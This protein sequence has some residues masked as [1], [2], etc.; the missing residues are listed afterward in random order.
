MA[1]VRPKD[2]EAQA[3]HDRAEQLEYEHGSY[4][5]EHMLDELP[6][7]ELEQR[8]EE[9]R[10]AHAKSLAAGRARDR[11]LKPARWQNFRAGGRA[12]GTRVRPKVKARRV[13]VD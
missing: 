13:G 3:L 9:I 11:G 5:R 1:R 2:A 8:R 12:P 7:P 10:K 6:P 4:M